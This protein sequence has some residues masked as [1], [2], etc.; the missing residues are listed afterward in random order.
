[1]AAPA[2]SPAHVAAPASAAVRAAVLVGVA[3]EISGAGAAYGVDLVRGARMAADEINASG[4]V[5]GRPIV[6]SVADGGTNP[7][8][9]AIA[10]R[11]LALSDASV[12][13]GGWGSSQVLASLE[14]SEQGGLP[15]VVTG[16]THPAITSARNRWTFRVVHGEEMAVAALAE[17]AL[18][19]LRLRR[20]AVVCD[21]SAYGL[22]SHDAMLQRLQALRS[23]P[24]MARVCPPATTDPLDLAR[25]VA[26]VRADGL[27]FFSTEPWA[28]S[29]LKA[30]RAQ[31]GAVQVLGT[32]G[33]FNQRLVDALGPAAE[34]LLVT[35]LFHEAL[36][37]ESEAWARRY[38]AH[39]PG[40]AG[41]PP[42]PPL[43][44]WAYRA[45]RLIVAP[46]LDASTIADREA[47]RLRLS[48]WQG[49]V[50]GVPGV[51][52]FDTVRQLKQ[53]VRLQQVVQG[54]FELWRGA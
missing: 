11:R 42:Q 20:I 28:V 10:M 9:A 6:L 44:A 25:E 29:V 37:A 53:P 27:A 19:A 13:V 54:R 51:T 50:F 36:D 33:L 12:V 24:V 8:R 15:F 45:L 14:M 31:A 2:L 52:R 41:P 30:L 1:M 23:A 49:R 3:S 26:A 5:G 21:G 35:G 18:G 43:A 7:A 40:W 46:C 34:G 22:A 38:R 16:A 48:A 32:G 47:L 17:A 39:P 4:G